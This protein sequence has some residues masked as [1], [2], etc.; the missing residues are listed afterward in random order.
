MA[1]LRPRLH[2]LLKSLFFLPHQ[3]GL[4]ACLYMCCFSNGEKYQRWCRQNA[5][6]TV[7]VNRLDYHG[8]FKVYLQMRL[9]DYEGLVLKNRNS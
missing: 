3:N 8:L 9:R 6:L 2:V 7:S 4:N 1:S 5:T